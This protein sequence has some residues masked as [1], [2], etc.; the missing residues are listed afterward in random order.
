ME[1][2]W[3][4]VAEWGGGGGGQNP[5]EI[6][7]P[8]NGC[9]YVVFAVGGMAGNGSDTTVFYVYGFRIVMHMCLTTLAHERS[10]WWSIGEGI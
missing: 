6:Q 1:F 8:G 10:N 2:A 7:S 4:G 3:E 9:Q 5:A